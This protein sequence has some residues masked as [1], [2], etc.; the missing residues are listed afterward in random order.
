MMV[1]ENALVEM[2]EV[3]GGDGGGAGEGLRSTRHN[4]SMS[5]WNGSWVF[6]CALGIGPIFSYGRGLTQQ[7]NIIKDLYLGHRE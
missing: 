1:G 2:E 3:M 6:I 4:E 5:S 7:V